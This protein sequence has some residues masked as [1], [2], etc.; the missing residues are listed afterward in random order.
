MTHWYQYYY[1]HGDFSCSPTLL[2]R[3]EDQQEY[4]TVVAFWELKIKDIIVIK[5]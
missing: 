3:R 5:E 2:E 1:Y 4:V